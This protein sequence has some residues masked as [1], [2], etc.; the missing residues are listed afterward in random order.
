MQLH[1]WIHVIFEIFMSRIINIP[2]CYFTMR[3]RTRFLIQVNKRFQIVSYIWIFHKC[4]PYILSEEKSDTLA[5]KCHSLPSRASTRPHRVPIDLL[6]A[7]EKKNNRNP[8]AFLREPEKI[9]AKMQRV[10]MKQAHARTKD[11]GYNSWGVIRL[12]EFRIEQVL[13][14]RIA[15]RISIFTFAKD[16]LLFLHERKKASMRFLWLFI[17]DNIWYVASCPI[18]SNGVLCDMHH[19]IILNRPLDSPN[20]PELGKIK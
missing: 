2:I 10:E 20:S 11:R 19:E 17:E 14:S 16:L 8:L 13:D 5:A 9:E 3:E 15:F 18:D 12:H 7:L 4:K 6:P 1:N